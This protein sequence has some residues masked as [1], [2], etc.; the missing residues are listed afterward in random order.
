MSLDEKKILELINKTYQ[1][2]SNDSQ[3]IEKIN[4]Y[5]NS[6]PNYIENISKEY[7]LKKRKNYYR[8]G[9]IC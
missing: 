7:T 5:I 6:L 9:S 2:Y 8:I 4:D 1:K 3:I